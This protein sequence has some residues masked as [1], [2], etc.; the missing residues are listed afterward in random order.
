MSSFDNSDLYLPMGVPVMNRYTLVWTSLEYAT[1]ADTIP[2]EMSSILAGEIRETVIEAF[3]VLRLALLA[4][5][6]VFGG[7]AAVGGLGGFGVVGE[8]I[9]GFDCVVFEQFFGLNMSTVNLDVTD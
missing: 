8:E 6:Y 2:I 4:V 3:W 9:F 7:W 1:T 5:L